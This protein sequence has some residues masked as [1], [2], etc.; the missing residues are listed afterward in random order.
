MNTDNTEEIVLSNKEI[1]TLRKI[2]DVGKTD[3]LNGVSG[4]FHRFFCKIDIILGKVGKLWMYM[5]E[6]AGISYIFYLISQFHIG[7]AMVKAAS[8]E[9]TMVH[10]LQYIKATKMVAE[11]VN[12]IVAGIVLVIPAVIAILKTAKKIFRKQEVPTEEALEGQEESDGP[13]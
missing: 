13:R 6:V 2:L 5:L 3:E 1:T 4:T 9:T 10:A 11:S 7:L 12:G 8:T